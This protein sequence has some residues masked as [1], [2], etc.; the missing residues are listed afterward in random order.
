M[1]QKVRGIWYRSQAV[2][3]EPA[4]DI[5]ETETSKIIG[6]C[7]THKGS[8]IEPTRNTVSTAMIK[9]DQFFNRPFLQTKI[10]FLVSI[11]AF[12][13]LEMS[14]LNI[15]LWYKCTTLAAFLHDLISIPK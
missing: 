5:Q 2:F 15:F 13:C 8:A 12:V 4:I 11:S 9:K 3:L 6:N 10:S 14:G 7:K 1:G